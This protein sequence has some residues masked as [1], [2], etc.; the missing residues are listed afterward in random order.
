M[1]ELVDHTA[2]LLAEGLPEEIVRA[3]VKARAEELDMATWRFLI[4]GLNRKVLR[5][6]FPR[7]LVE[8]AKHLAKNTRHRSV[9]DFIESFTAKIGL[10]EWIVDNALAV[11][12][13]GDPIPMPHSLVGGVTVHPMNLG[14]E[15]TDVIIAAAGPLSNPEEIAREFLDTYYR[16]FKGKILERSPN[17]ERDARWLRAFYDGK[18]DAEIA[19]DELDAK[20]PREIVWENPKYHEEHRRMTQT[21][22]QGRT[23]LLARVTQMV[24]SVSP[25]SETE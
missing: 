8:V 14:G 19:W 21:V 12:R 23:R 24:G 22:K 25:D 13:G 10:D 6:P 7:L 15:R 11:A 9:R 17:E 2:A 18:S 5:Y 1:H 20:Y 4:P 16:T 3:R